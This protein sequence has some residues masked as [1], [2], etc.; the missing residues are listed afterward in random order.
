MIVSKE[1]DFGKPVVACRSDSRS[2][3]VTDRISA[4][5]K[6]SECVG[7]PF[8]IDFEDFV[9]AWWEDVDAVMSV[10]VGA[11]ENRRG[12]GERIL[13]S[14]RYV[15]NTSNL[16]QYVGNP[17]FVG[18][19]YTIVVFVVKDVAINPSGSNLFEVI[20]DSVSAAQRNVDVGDNVN[21]FNRSNF[22]TFDSTRSSSDVQKIVGLCLNQL[23]LTRRKT[24]LLTKAVIAI[25]VGLSRGNGFVNPRVI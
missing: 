21:V 2:T 8:V 13:G 16:N 11:N 4:I 17:L 6:R 18:V 1:N 9:N 14:A 10:G 19:K 12:V 7:T 23:V 15:A 3:N 24:K 25:S 20:V 22:F 5:Y